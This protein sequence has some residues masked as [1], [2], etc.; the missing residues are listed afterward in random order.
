LAEFIIDEGL[1]IICLCNLFN[2]EIEWEESLAKNFMGFFHD[3]IP[4]KVTMHITHSQSNTILLSVT[5][6]STKDNLESLATIA[7]LRKNEFSFEMKNLENISYPVRKLLTEGTQHCGMIETFLFYD[8]FT[9][10]RRKL[11]SRSYK[12]KNLA[13]CKCDSVEQNKG[14]F[15]FLEMSPCSSTLL[16]YP[17]NLFEE[18]EILK[19]R[20]YDAD[21][22]AKI[23][24]TF[25]VLSYEF[26]V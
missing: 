13:T 5:D 15:F 19:P 26:P 21:L 9:T 8:V 4:K 7:L 12:W 3:R 22:S 23:P 11:P 20:A 14:R 24:A 1:N 18:N 17:W 10:T 2:P 6:P 16:P 25:R